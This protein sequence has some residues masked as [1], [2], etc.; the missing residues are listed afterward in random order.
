LTQPTP[1]RSTK[2]VKLHSRGRK[3]TDYGNAER[4]VAQHRAVVRFVPQWRQWI[5]WTGKRWARDST[6]EAIRLAKETVRSIYQEASAERD[7][8]QRKAIASHAARSES[9]G[10]LKAM[11]ELAESEAGIP[12][13]PNQLDADAMLLNVENGTIDLRAGTLRP[14][15]PTDLITK[16]APVAF[17][18]QAV[19]AAWS[20]FLT[21]VTDADADLVA[22]L[23]RLA[24]YCVTGLTIEKHFFFAFGP[25]DTGKST[26][27]DALAATLGDYAASAAPETWLLQ[28]TTGGNRGDLARLL[29]ARLVFSSEFRRGSRFDESLLKGITGGDALTVAAKYQS[30]FTYRP[31]YKLIFAANDAPR[32]ADTDEGMWQRCLRVPFANSVPAEK[33]DPNLKRTLCQD[34]AARSAILAWMVQGALE[35]QATGLGVPASVKAST[36]AYRAENDPVGGF[37]DDCLV[38]EMK[39]TAT[40]KELRA[41]YDSWCKSEGVK[42][43]LGPREFAERLK[44]RE[45]KEHRTKSQRCWVGVRLRGEW[46]PEAGDAVTS[47]DVTSQNSLHEE[48][49]GKSY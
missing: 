15:S 18:P 4:F 24:G 49:Y 23:Q 25:P 36:E 37:F 28:T 48:I 21:D 39:A 43:T 9:V 5:H 46:E 27:L 29:G 1:E 13:E 2:V 11:L 20:K 3:L 40:A 22:F 44:G 38:F 19:H 26:F 33:R 7:A 45:C 17:E 6:G 41:S 16:L 34:P 35:W 10:R 30:E 42:F 32:I 12:I 14:H 8:D 31:T 47:G